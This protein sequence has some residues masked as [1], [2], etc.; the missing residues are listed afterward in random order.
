MGKVYL[1]HHAMLRRPVAVKFLKPDQANRRTL[2]WFEREV[3]LA[4]QLTHPNTIEIYDY[5]TS[6]EGIFFYVMEYLPGI[7]L[8]EL[9]QLEGPIPWPRVVYILR[10]V[11]GSLREAH[12]TGLVHRDI[13]P[14]NIMLC[15]RGREWDVVK[16]LDF[17]L[18]KNLD[19]SDAQ[20]LN[21]SLVLAGTPLYMSPE[22]LRDPTCV[23]VRSDIYSLGA[24]A[25]RLLT[26]TEIFTGKSE[27]EIL[28]QV[29]DQDAPTPSQATSH[30]IPSEL[31][32]LV[33][34]CLA[35]DV[36]ARPESVAEMIR[37][38]TGLADPQA[39]NS[40]MARDWW[41]RSRDQIRRLRQ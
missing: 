20:T 37:V 27:I 15:E 24:V 10:Q 17:G 32:Q 21:R 1:A 40:A 29:L 6:P 28:A 16:V 8:E 13:K 2:A 33:V 12:E 30:E 5:G 9:V 11:C 22:R 7:T 3:Q 25:F 26:G 38:I 4:S 31:D 35:K 14:H 19:V 41:E 36:A 34:A 18:V 23:D 39:W